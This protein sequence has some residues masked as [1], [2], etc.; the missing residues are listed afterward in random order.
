M[1]SLYQTPVVI[2]RKTKPAK[3]NQ[4]IVVNLTF[5]FLLGVI[6]CKW[7]INHTKKRIRIYLPVTKRYLAE[8]L[9]HEWGGTIVT[10]TRG[11]HRGIMWQT[12]STRSFNKIKAAMTL[13]QESL[14]PEFVTQL[15][16]FM[17]EF[18]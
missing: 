13:V 11:K 3:A 8:A 1:R 18:V 16:L 4:P 10:I 2:S 14:P 17:L 15:D 6:A 9:K 7:W 5:M 12:T